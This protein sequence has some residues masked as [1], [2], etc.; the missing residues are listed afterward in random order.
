MLFS[1]SQVALA[2]TVSAMD[3][4]E[5]AAVA[6]LRDTFQVS[7]QVARVLLRSKTPSEARRCRLC[8]I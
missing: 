4:A 3:P 1:S 7:C 2:V 8:V 6:R 5:A